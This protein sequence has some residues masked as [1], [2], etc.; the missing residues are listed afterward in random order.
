MVA[1]RIKTITGCQK[2]SRGFVGILTGIKISFGWIQGGSEVFQGIL[3]TVS[4]GF[5]K[6]FMK[7]FR[8][9]STL[10]KEFQWSFRVVSGGFEGAGFQIVFRGTSKVFKAFQYF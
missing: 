6:S 8:N 4:R 3:E 5:W 2:Y 7:V 10:Q 9:V 1:R